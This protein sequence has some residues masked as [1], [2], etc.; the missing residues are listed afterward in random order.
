MDNAENERK[1]RLE[2][3]KKLLNEKLVDTEL[4]ISYLKDIASDA[5]NAI[6]D[7]NASKENI[8]KELSILNIAGDEIHLIDDS[9]WIEYDNII[10]REHNHQSMFSLLSQDVVNNFTNI[11]NI[12]T[13]ASSM[14]GVTD[15]GLIT[16]F[17]TVSQISDPTI[18]NK[19]QKLYIEDTLSEKVNFIRNQ[20]HSIFPECLYE[21]NDAIKSWNL[22]D[23]AVRHPV[24]LS[25]RSVIFYQ[26]F[27]TLSPENVYKA[28]VWFNSNTTSS[29]RDKPNRERYCQSKCFILGNTNTSLLTPISLQNV[30][31]ISDSLFTDFGSLSQYGKNGGPDY[32]VKN[33]FDLTISDFVEAIKLRQAHYS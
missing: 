1:Q 28:K 14:K 20:L 4:S 5:T 27:D 30:E 9:A 22:K 7:L 32:I 11:Q 33:T 17:N 26:I 2:D 15:S 13:S 6:K 12:S 24:L 29:Y 8:Q 23:G 21:Y 25:L 10:I 3:H 16:T 18:K 31:Y 19:L